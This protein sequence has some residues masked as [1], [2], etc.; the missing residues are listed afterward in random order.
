MTYSP[1]VD[2]KH[3]E[4]TA[5][6]SLERWV[7]Y[8]HQLDL[9]Q[10]TDAASVLEIGMGAGIVTRELQR[11]G[12]ATKTADIAADL[13]PDFVCS[14]TQLTVPDQSFDLVLAAEILEHI[15]FDDV[16]QALREMARVSRSHVLISVPHPGFVSSLI[17]KLPKVRFSLLFKIPFF[18][19]SRTATPEHYWE[20]GRPGYS[21]PR[22]IEVAKAAGLTLVTTKSYVDD[23]VHRFFLFSK[24]V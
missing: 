17:V 14:V 15:H 3:Y 7:S 5:Y 12:I 8:W 24:K 4:G 23:P 9:V 19:K 2:S 22:F 11:R 6:R 20:L 13:R 1:Q 21:V 16:P 18:W 10:K